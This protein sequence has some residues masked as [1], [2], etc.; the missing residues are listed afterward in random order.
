[1]I[2]N[3]A[4]ISGLFGDHGLPA[5]TAAK[6]GVANL[7]RTLAIDLAH[8]NIRVNAVC[9]GPVETAMTRNMADDQEIMA[10]YRRL[11]PMATHGPTRRDRRGRRLPGL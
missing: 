9:P 5:Y 4:S 1:M 8:E 7:T 6:A 10:E 2:V 3:T 11:I